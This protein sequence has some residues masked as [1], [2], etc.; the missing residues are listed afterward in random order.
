[1]D[2]KTHHITTCWAWRRGLLEY[3]NCPKRVGVPPTPQPTRTVKDCIHLHTRLDRVRGDV[4][5]EDLSLHHLSEWDVSRQ[6]LLQ[7]LSE[8]EELQ[9]CCVLEKNHLFCVVFCVLSWKGIA[10]FVL[11]SFR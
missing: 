8:S 10:C 2:Q 11:C 1:M 4:A 9:M 7:S 3:P 5:E 6:G